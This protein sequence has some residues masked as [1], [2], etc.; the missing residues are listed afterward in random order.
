MLRKYRSHRFLSKEIS[1][2]F[3][4]YFQNWTTSVLVITF[5]QNFYIVELQRQK[6]ENRSTDLR[7]LPQ[8]K[9]KKVI[10]NQ[11]FF[12]V[13]WCMLLRYKEIFSLKKCSS[14]KAL[15]KVVANV[16]KITNHNFFPNFY[17]L[18]LQ[19]QKNENGSTV[20]RFLLQN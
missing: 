10:W 19:R 5:F 15:K 20:L 17:I 9:A 2:W 11:H 1:K 12:L 4:K 6:I 8:N 16:S 13:S 14:K 7:F 3:S 18:E